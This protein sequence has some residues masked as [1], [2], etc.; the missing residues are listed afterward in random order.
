MFISISWQA[1]LITLLGIV[2]IYYL[3]ILLMY[4]RAEFISLFVGKENRQDS[5]E[6]FQT[7]SI[8][9]E[10]KQDERYSSVSSEELQFHHETEI[11]QSENLLIPTRHED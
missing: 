9:G 7:D 10:V 6:D 2:A 4:Y 3:S 1:Y 5:I 8:M 11:E